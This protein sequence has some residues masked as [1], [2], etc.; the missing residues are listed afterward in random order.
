MNDDDDNQKI[1]EETLKSKL[2]WK[3]FESPILLNSENHVKDYKYLNPEAEC[4]FRVKTIKYNIKNDDEENMIHKKR[5][6]IE[7][8]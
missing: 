3:N 6:A 1:Y 5:H 7:K 2:K 8:N 4:Y